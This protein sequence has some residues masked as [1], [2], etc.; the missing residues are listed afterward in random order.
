MKRGSHASPE[1]SAK[2][3]KA[4]DTEA[5]SILRDFLLNIQKGHAEPLLASLLA[6]HAAIEWA[7]PLDCAVLQAFL[8]ISPR[9][10]QLL[11]LWGSSVWVDDKKRELFAPLMEILT[12]VAA[13][14]RATD[15]PVAEA[16]GLAIL[17]NKMDWIT[18]QLTWSDKPRIEHATL[19]LC[20]E[21]VSTNARLAREF[22]RLFDFGAKFFATL[23]GRRAKDVT[24]PDS[25][26][27]FSVRHSFVCF[28]LS[29]TA[30]HDEHV[31]RFMVKADG[32]THSLFKSIDGDTLPDVTA[33]LSTLES[34]VLAKADVAHKHNVLSM[35]AISQLLKLLESP[36]D[37]ICDLA[38]AFLHK[39]FFAESALYHVSQ[40]STLPFLTKKGAKALHLTETD[41]APTSIAASIVT[42]VLKSFNISASLGDPKREALLLEFLK[43]YPGLVL[44]LFE[45]YLV[46]V[47]PRPSFKWFSA[48]S[49]VLQSLRLPLTPLEATLRA[50]VD[51]A[52]LDG[53]KQLLLPVGLT[54]SVLTKAL[55]HTD[56]LV[57]YTTLNLV[58]VVL[59][60][61]ATV[62]ALL[63]KDVLALLEADVLRGMLPPPE[64]MLTLC[65]KYRPSD[66]EQHSSKMELVC[67]RALG[68]LQAYFVYLP[69]TMG[70][71]KFDISKLLLP[72]QVA[73]SLLGALLQLLRVAEPHR[74]AYIVHGGDATKFQSLLRHC[75]S[76]QPAIATL[77]RHVVRRTLA[78]LQ[79][80]GL[81]PVYDTYTPHE[82]DV[83]LAQLGRHPDALAFFDSLVRA[84]AANPFACPGAP[85]LSPVTRALVSYLSSAEMPLQ[86]K[87]NDVAAATAF[88]VA[89]LRNLQPLSMAPRELV[90][91]TIERDPTGVVA[92][93]VA[94]CTSVEKKAN[95]A[96]ARTLTTT[97][98][99]ETLSPTESLV[100]SEP[101]LIASVSHRFAAIE[102]YMSTHGS[103]SLF[104]SDV[105]Q[106][107]FGKPSTK[108]RC[109]VTHFFA[110][111]PTHVVLQSLFHPHVLLRGG[112]S[113]VPSASALQSYLSTR[114]A[115]PDASATL[116]ALDLVHSLSVY[117]ARYK[118][119]VPASKTYIKAMRAAVSALQLL[120]VHVAMDSVPLHESFWHRV[121]AHHADVLSL[122]RPPTTRCSVPYLPQL[123]TPWGET[124][125]LAIAMAA[126]ASPSEVH[127]LVDAMLST[128]RPNVRLVLHLLDLS[129]HATLHRPSL[130]ARVV[131]IALSHPKEASPKAWLLHYIQQHHVEDDA[132]LASLFELCWT[133]VSSALHLS[134]LQEL[135]VKNAKCRLAFA[136]LRSSSHLLNEACLPGVLAVAATYLQSAPLAPDCVQWIRDVIVPT[137]VDAILGDDASTSMTSLPAVLDAL[138][139]HN[140]SGDVDF[141]VD[142]LVQNKG[143]L[144]SPAQ[145]QVF[146]LA[147]KH[148]NLAPNAFKLLQFALQQL[149][150]APAGVSADACAYVVETLLVAHASDMKKLPTIAAQS[151]VKAL[152]ADR[153][154]LTAPALHRAIK[155]MAVLLPTTVDFV[156][157]ARVIVAALPQQAELEPTLVD[158][159]AAI[160]AT[161]RDGST[162]DLVDLALLKALL[163]RYSASLS[164]VD[165]A[166]QSVLSLLET[167]FDVRLET[168][169]YCFG[170]A[171]HVSSSSLSS[172]KSH[173]LLEEIEP[174]RMR[175]SIEYFPLHRS[176][177]GGACDA[178]QEQSVYD[179][180]FFL[181]LVAH[182]LST[183]HIP[184]KQLLQSG[185]LGY[186][187]CAL[188]AEDDTIRA[189]AYGIVASAH[190]AMS[191]TARSHDFHERR[192]IHLLLETL[193]NGVRSTHERLPSLLTVFANDA[194][195][196]LLRPGH[197]MYPLINAF[198]LAR[199]AL[200]TTDVPMFYTLFNSS[201]TTY[202]QERSWLLHIIKRGVR[203]NIDVD[204]LQRRH[205]Y[206]ILLTFFD[207]PLADAYTQDFVLHILSRSV[208]TPHGVFTLV[209]K[210]GLLAWLECALLRHFQS[211][212]I[213]H[214]LL[215]IATTAIEAYESAEKNDAKY[216]LNVVTQLQ[217]LC[218]TM[219]QHASSLPATCAP[220]LSRLLSQYVAFG[221][222]SADTDLW[223]SL[224]LLECLVHRSTPDEARDVAQ[225]V[226]RCFA[227][228]SNAARSMQFSPATYARW[229]A[230]AA[231]VGAHLS[232]DLPQT[233]PA[234]VHALLTASPAFASAF[235]YNRTNEWGMELW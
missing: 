64:V 3:A 114:L 12:A 41:E 131:A 8:D 155:T 16:F 129:A 28:V 40:I 83:W 38:K 218:K 228:V 133:D 68:V 146:V 109:I 56:M 196:V 87:V 17:K 194:I 2:K 204:L 191:V 66:K 187:I 14:L 220:L 24:I 119:N 184:D 197:A 169:H 80:F 222:A 39:I 170:K 108:K 127:D 107:G 79:I 230:L 104:D 99:L 128:T 162:D 103:A 172:V 111:A 11:D 7:S 152:A 175:K 67:A 88:G 37:A 91:P 235:S 185:I 132:L 192:Q 65:T 21:L 145:L 18:K 156:P 227:R 233:F 43:H 177:T 168:A 216:R 29:L 232:G 150:R 42:K 70:E 173:W 209:H 178:D 200:D 53:L 161:A 82:I 195:S 180:A 96:Y 54:K 174:A 125:P 77:G 115:T 203:L 105:L 74:L 141:L 19:T 226:A 229:A 193:K 198:L 59:A 112:Q 136:S 4:P 202:R 76:A 45:S 211:D 89:V 221:L 153:A 231:F 212:V 78:A 201:A 158:A 55:Q 143:K 72:S 34:T 5:S 149:S 113:V 20:N 13:K 92:A 81:A 49:F 73:P 208:A 122:S 58:A 71:T 48:A 75:L 171:N 126:H 27:V 186:A 223:F 224:D 15:V 57:V 199:S 123:V 25:S 52:C 84:V 160:L 116:A 124:G 106:A 134:L 97:T 85:S 102:Q 210:F 10:D 23:C 179:P 213:A 205:V 22:V 215:S 101:L 142:G 110:T 86:L 98:S 138:P 62:T 44:P 33:I 47:Q 46:V 26:R 188:S 219:V 32:P 118:K 121:W 30:S 148:Y 234:T 135:V 137:C 31:Y 9:A 183:S 206:A 144:L 214:W 100:V 189:Y 167:K 140:L 176:F 139:E 165:V 61:V 147:T 1:R 69:Q 95:K 117:L 50:H 225:L 63:S 120:L 35:P 60:R 94:A 217:Q 154:W 159:L 182:T 130:F 163:S 166:L 90:P 157:L 36:D 51:V 207:S 190:E 6:F 151:V 164:H 181:P 93:F